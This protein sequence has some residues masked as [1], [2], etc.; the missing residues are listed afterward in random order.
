MTTTVSS[1][2]DFDDFQMKERSGSISE[3]LG[4]P[5][6]ELDVAKEKEFIAANPY[7]ESGDKWHNATT[8]HKL[9]IVSGAVLV[10]G[11]I[12]PLLVGAAATG[13]TMGAGAPVGI[14]FM[15]VGLASIVTGVGLMGYGAYNLIRRKITLSRK[16]NEIQK[17]YQGSIHLNEIKRDLVAFKRDSEHLTLK[18]AKLKLLHIKIK[19]DSNLSIDQRKDLLSMFERGPKK[20]NVNYLKN[21][22]DRLLQINE[23]EEGSS[24]ITSNLRYKLEEFKEKLENENISAKEIK[25]V[26]KAFSSL[27]KTESASK[28]YGES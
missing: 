23:I 24:K 28:Y 25:L 26:K 5:G 10:G 16:T 20:K 27:L 21:N 2:D 19:Y 8:S 6:I 14:A 15:G 11:G 17:K 3:G 12:A 7:R 4:A 1:R 9:S 18:E 22:Y 13:A